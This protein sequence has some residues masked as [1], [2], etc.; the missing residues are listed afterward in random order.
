MEAS[1]KLLIGTK[2]EDRT[3]L[4]ILHI[5]DLH[6]D[7]YGFENLI[8]LKDKIRENKIIYDLV[9]ISGD[10]QSYWIKDWKDLISWAK[11]EE[12]IISILGYAESICQNVYFIPGNHDPSDL[13]LNPQIKT[14][15][16][17]S[18]RPDIT[19]EMVQLKE[20]WYNMHGNIIN[21]AKGLKLAGYGGSKDNFLEKD[22]K[23][24]GTIWEAFPYA[25]EED[26]SVGLKSMFAKLT[27]EYATE[28]PFQLILMTHIG[29]YSSMSAV[30][31]K[32]RA[33]LGE[34]IYS[35]SKTLENLIEA[36]SKFIL[37]NIHGHNHS[38]EKQTEIGGVPIL[39]PNAFFFGK[40][41]EYKL[42]INEKKKWEIIEINFL[43]V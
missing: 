27:H 21:I 16:L 5:T 24:T 40:Y 28:D 38:S 31:T 43:E 8:M 10:M 15:G 14:P 7:K 18:D 42:K 34:N 30:D 36:N 32:A 23:I 19:D 4:R 13:F 20:N 17:I 39:N 2:L 26:F 35:G 9:L 6:T 29:P 11:A 3:E 1:D 22:G 37:C 41:A 25:D 12:E 33:N